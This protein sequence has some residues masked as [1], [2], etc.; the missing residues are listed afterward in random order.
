MTKRVRSP[1]S[2]LKPFIY[3]LAMEQGLV[4]QETLIEDRPANFCGLPAPQLRHELSGRCER[5]AGIAALAERPG[6]AP[7]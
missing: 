4:A 3:G 2:T 5:K 1:G 6:R 7:A